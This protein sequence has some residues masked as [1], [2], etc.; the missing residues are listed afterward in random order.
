[1]YSNLFIDIKKN[2]NVCFSYTDRVN[3]YLHFHCKNQNLTEGLHYEDK[4]LLKNF[5][6]Y[7]K[8]KKQ[9]Y[10][11]SDSTYIHYTPYYVEF[12]F[13]FG[14]IKLSLI[15]NSN[16][17]IHQY[18]VLFV[19]YTILKNRNIQILYS[20]DK[21]IEPYF[22]TQLGKE[23]NKDILNN[24]FI[25]NSND[26]EYYITFEKKFEKCFS[27]LYLEH[28]NIIDSFFNNIEIKLPE[29]ESNFSDA[30][31]WAM[32]SGWL[33]VTGEKDRGIWAGLPWFRDNWGRDTFISYPGIL[34]VTG[35]FQEAKAVISSFANYQDK[36]VNS[37]T[38]GRI[39]NRYRNEDDVIFNTVDGTLWFIREVWEYLQ[40]TGDI[41]FL[42]EIWPVIKLAIDTDMDRRTDKHGFLLHG[43]ADTWMDARIQGN[44]P[45]SPRGDKG[46]DIQVLWFTAL[47]IGSKIAKIVNEEVYSEKLLIEAKRIHENFIKYYYNS[48]MNEIVDCINSEYK[49]DT[50]IRPNQFMCFSVPL[51]GNMSKLLN[52]EEC[53]KTIEKAFSKLV[54]KYGVLSLSQDD[55]H[56]H[57][58]HDRSDLYHKDAAYH[59]GTIWL[60][61]SGFVVDSLCLTDNQQTAYKLSKIH[62]KQMLDTKT[63]KFD[64]R[65]IGSLSENINAYKVNNKICPSGTWSQAWS[66]SEF[67]RNAIQ[68]Y[69][70]VRLDIINQN[71]NFAPHFPK[72]WEY[73]SVLIPLKN[74]KCKLEWKKINENKKD[75]TIEY[76]YVFSLEKPQNIFITLI[77]NFDDKK[78]YTFNSNEKCEFSSTVQYNQKLSFAKCYNEN[79]FWKKPKSVKELNFL[80]KIILKKSNN[81]FSPVK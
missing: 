72:E 3:S 50:K 53:K 75:N 80:E 12:Y 64:S 55:E 6:F 8:Q 41:E 1:M 57:P 26:N 69:I 31:Q 15:I 28:I 33:L 34:L 7:D 18:P 2:S 48:E 16:L 17:Q 62:A 46:N 23:I 29:S 45:W 58:Y 4:V 56:F 35:Q 27:K 19:E 39:P 20:T 74:N 77:N 9:T 65:C 52:P 37:N 24:F 51:L 67:S 54:V 79:I 73:G 70:G 10:T 44:Q 36:N 63:S 40:Y 21:N 32:F 68:S 30:I 61:N 22:Y 76:R 60:W 59:N 71:I 47:F 14:I 38:Y 78:V 25:C 81:Y 43:D 13:E 5:Y 66:V 42:K 49:K 11:I